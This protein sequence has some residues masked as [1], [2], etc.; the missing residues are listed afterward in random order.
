MCD[1][2]FCRGV[3]V[4]FIRLGDREG[5]FRKGRTTSID[6]CVLLSNNDN[7]DK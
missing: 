6:R 5:R 7:R 3:V 1:V 2:I 4:V